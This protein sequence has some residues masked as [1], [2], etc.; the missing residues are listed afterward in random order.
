MAAT[1]DLIVSRIGP[2]APLLLLMANFGQIRDTIKSTKAATEK[3]KLNR[4]KQII[5]LS[6]RRIR[7]TPYVKSINSPF[8]N[9]LF[10]LF[11]AF[12]ILSCP[13][14]FSAEI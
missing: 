11:Q 13:V 7:T 14:Y 2:I 1:L 8:N 9:W 4:L 12:V 10:D 3:E 5:F 6:W